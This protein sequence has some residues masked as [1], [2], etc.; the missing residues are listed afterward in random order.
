MRSILFAVRFS[1]SILVTLSALCSIAF[2]FVWLCPASCAL[3]QLV[4]STSETVMA[5]VESVRQELPVSAFFVL[6][7]PCRIGFFLKGLV[8]YLCV[9]T[10]PLFG[11]LCVV[12]RRRRRCH[13]SAFGSGWTRSLRPSAVAD[14]YRCPK[15]DARAFY[16]RCP[17]T[18]PRR[19]R[20]SGPLILSRMRP[21]VRAPLDWR[22][23]PT[24]VP[25]RRPPFATLGTGIPSAGVAC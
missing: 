12:R 11:T 16:E 21:T 22:S 3:L 18:L 7:S 1:S 24:G 14:A 15:S 20:G 23:I 2:A 5:K 8:L 9:R 6:R 13:S 25:R 17:T 4:P 10:R 19:G